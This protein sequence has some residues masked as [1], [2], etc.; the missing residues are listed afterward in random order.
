[1]D[2]REIETPC[3]VCDEARL[4]QNLELLGELQNRT[5]C[6]V[7]LALKAFAMFSTFPLMRRYLA[8]TAASSLNE[9]RLGRE[10]FGGELH[11]CAPAYKDSEFEQLLT[12]C[13]HMVFNSFSQWRHF[14]P[15]IDAHGGDTRCGIRINPEHSE[16][17]TAIY[18][19][20]AANS[21]LGVRRVDFESGCL[22]GITGLH[23]HVLC[24]HDADALV[25]TL[26][27]FEEKFGEFLPAMKWVNFGG[28]HHIT[29]DGYD[30]DG[31]CAAIDDFRTRHDVVVYLEPGEGIVMN[32]AVLVAS[33]LDVLPNDTVIL[34]ASASAHMPDV[35]E[36]PYRVDIRGAG[37]PGEFDYTYWI[38]GLTCMAGDVFG[39]Y[40][41]AQPLEVGSRVVFEDM[42]PYTMVKNTMFNGVP[43]PRIAIEE[44]GS[45]RIREVRR[46]DYQDYR[47]RLS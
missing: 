43:L 14:K 1:M 6:V 41:F 24:G 34:D 19:P 23:F 32:A 15:R 46:F 21:R 12:L 17:E 26:L 5:G 8:G 45:G 30:I 11:M 38:G 39:Q 35:L 13:D 2:P 47:K 31:L 22:D 44:A 25:R 29:R 37:E 20:C 28:G 18:D 16:V 33:V 3:Y 4:L 9:A 36:M 40:S 10:E 27:V 42:A 7:L